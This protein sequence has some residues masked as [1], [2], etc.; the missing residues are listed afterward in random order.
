MYTLTVSFQGTGKG[1]VVSFDAT[2]PATISCATTCSAQF[3]DNISPYLGATAFVG[4][5]F[6]GFSTNC[7]PQEHSPSTCQLI[8]YSGEGDETVQVTFNVKPPPCIAPSVKGET[9]AAARMWIKQSHCSVGSV[10]RA[11]STKVK[12]G[13]VVSQSPP[14]KWQN[15][16][17]SPIDL[18]VSKGRR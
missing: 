5:S 18:V 1:F 14:G 12:K 15:K 13:H 11:F 10:T 17:G 4:S 16:P 9:V 3:P 2:A 6:G 7:P 8:H